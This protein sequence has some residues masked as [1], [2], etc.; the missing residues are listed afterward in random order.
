MVSRRPGHYGLCASIVTALYKVTF[1][2]GIYRG[3]LSVQACAAGYALIYV[4]ALKLS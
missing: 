4:T 2:Q 3:F 1:I